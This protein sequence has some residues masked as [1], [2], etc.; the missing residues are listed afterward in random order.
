MNSKIVLLLRLSTA[1]AFVG[2]TSL[3]VLSPAEQKGVVKAIL[4]TIENS[5]ALVDDQIVYEGDTVYG[6][7]VVEIE[8]R[9]VEFQKDQTQ[10]KQRVGQKPNPAWKELE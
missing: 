3:Y 5:S 7:T 1:A 10:W 4:Y 6:V 8:R 9:T 2:G